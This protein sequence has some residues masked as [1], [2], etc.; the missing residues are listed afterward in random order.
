MS[1]RSR[2]FS[3]SLGGSINGTKQQH[4]ATDRNV[5]IATN[6]PSRTISIIVVARAQHRVPVEGSNASFIYPKKIEM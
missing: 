5:D 3:S 2:S 6:G 4:K 1:A